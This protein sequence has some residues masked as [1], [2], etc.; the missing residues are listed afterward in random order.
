M[1]LLQGLAKG[2]KYSTIEYLITKNTSISKLYEDFEEKDLQIRSY[3]AFLRINT[4]HNLNNDAEALQEIKKN[5]LRNSF[6]YMKT[7]SADIENDFN[8]HNLMLAVFKKLPIDESRKVLEDEITHQWELRET[9]PKTE[10]Y[11]SKE[12]ISLSPL[13]DLLIKNELQNENFEKAIG[14]SAKIL[15]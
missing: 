2:G 3:L 1:Q 11:S 4:L 12:T 7:L 8:N 15:V 10:I 13:I 14:T 5:G 6:L 9:L